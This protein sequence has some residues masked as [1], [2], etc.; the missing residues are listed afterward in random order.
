VLADPW[1]WITSESARNP[2]NMLSGSTAIATIGLAAYFGFKKIPAEL[3]QRA[4]EKRRDLE[5]QKAAEVLTT[6]IRYASALEFVGSPFGYEVKP[7]E[8]I[9]S[10]G[11]N[12]LNVMD[13]RW[14][15]IEKEE[16][17][18]RQAQ[19]TALVYLDADV[20]PLVNALAEI[21]NRIR[22]GSEQL[23]P[24]LDT[25]DGGKDVA[26]QLREAHQVAHGNQERIDRALE[27]LRSRLTPI[28]RYDHALGRAPINRP[29]T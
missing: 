20:M 25:I 15:S 16:A 26:A 18:F 29:K 27:N 3:H 10:P 9:Q 4:L 14:E 28:A 11:Q 17:E 12:L 5:A 6:G 8:R 23:A 21:R 13:R 22:V 19:I 7:T 1:R 2:G 24:L